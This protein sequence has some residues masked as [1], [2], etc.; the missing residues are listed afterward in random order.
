M[1]NNTV[2]RPKIRQKG[3]DEYLKILGLNKTEEEEKVESIVKEEI[4]SVTEEIPAMERKETVETK[5][6][7]LKSMLKDELRT[8]A[9]SLGLDDSGTKANLIDRITEYHL[10]R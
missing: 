5:I 8:L 6:E 3:L 10:K 4:K 9:T 7:D 2:I 1:L